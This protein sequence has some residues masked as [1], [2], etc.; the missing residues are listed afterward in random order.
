MAEYRY[1]SNILWGRRYDPETQAHY[2][3]AEDY[4]DLRTKIPKSVDIQS[5]QIQTMT[6]WKWAVAP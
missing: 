1:Y 5:I 2:V 4:G 3:E 6:G